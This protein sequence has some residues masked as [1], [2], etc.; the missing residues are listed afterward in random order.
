MK[1]KILI[2]D[3]QEDILKSLAQY[4]EIC[5]FKV[6]ST[7][8][9]KKA[10]KLAKKEKPDLMLVDIRMPEMTGLELCSKVPEQKVL[11]MTAYN[12]YEKKADNYENSIGLIRKPIDTSLLIGIIK[13][14]FA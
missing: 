8:S 5:G 12:N 14:E 2:V 11:F 4:L 9:A 6:I 10:I 13:K 7:L 3:D 1:K